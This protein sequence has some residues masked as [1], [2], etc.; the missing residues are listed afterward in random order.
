M[1]YNKS[2]GH[3]CVYYGGLRQNLHHLHMYSGV[4][5]VIWGETGKMQVDTLPGQDG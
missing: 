1:D 5:G 3:L 4:P 2:L